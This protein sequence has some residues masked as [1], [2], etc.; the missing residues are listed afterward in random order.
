MIA[1]AIISLA[2]VLGWGGTEWQLIPD[3][4]VY[5]SAQQGH[6]MDEIHGPLLCEP[7]TWKRF[8]NA[9][10]QTWEGVR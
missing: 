9:V 4:R 2:V 3:G 7:R 10:E 8:V 5:C 1:W 6:V